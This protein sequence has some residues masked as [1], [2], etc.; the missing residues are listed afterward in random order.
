MD[1]IKEL[2]VCGTCKHS[3]LIPD[4]NG[5][6]AVNIC[7]IGS[8]AVNKDG[9]GSCHEVQV[10]VL[11]KGEGSQCLQNIAQGAVASGT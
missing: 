1:R 2:N 8:E 6:I 5:E 4:I 9:G 11:R 10:S 7:R 3:H